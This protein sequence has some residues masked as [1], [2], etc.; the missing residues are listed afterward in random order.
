MG[1]L[2]DSAGVP[3]VEARVSFSH[4][5]DSDARPRWAGAGSGSYLMG[6]LAPGRYRVRRPKEAGT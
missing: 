1:Q 6:D 4:L 3:L 2:L 5:D